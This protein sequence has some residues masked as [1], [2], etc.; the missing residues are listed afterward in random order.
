M[1]VLALAGA[2]AG[3]CGGD[4]SGGSASDEVKAATKDYLTGLAAGNGQ[5]AC[6]Q[7]TAG[8]QK[9]AI[10]AVTAAYPESPE[11]TCPQAITELSQDVAPDSKRA[12]LN[13]AFQAVEVD[14]GRAEARVKALHQTVRLERAGDDWKVA[15]GVSG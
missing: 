1:T 14:G 9:E 5:R 10:E 2:A 7:M 8:A 3:G 15:H 11:L 13:P 6:G 4:G 12:M